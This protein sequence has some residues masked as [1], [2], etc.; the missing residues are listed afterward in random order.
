MVDSSTSDEV[1]EGVTTQQNQEEEKIEPSEDNTEVN[2]SI[3][4]VCNVLQ[5]ILENAGMTRSCQEILNMM[6]NTDR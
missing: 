1:S 5:K 4:A 3:T 2:N 6:A